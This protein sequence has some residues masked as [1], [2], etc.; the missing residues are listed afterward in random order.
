M[1]FDPQALGTRSATLE[2]KTNDFVSKPIKVQLAGNGTA[3]PA[4]TAPSQDAQPRITL[5]QNARGTVQVLVCGKSKK[6]RKR[7][8]TITLTGVPRGMVRASLKRNGK[9]QAAATRRLANQKL[10]IVLRTGRKGRH[11]MTLTAPGT[12]KTR[13]VRVPSPDD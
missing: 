5:A 11:T 6:A 4:A 7:C 9:T 10:R 1:R 8:R 12:K 13:T 2:M 3:A